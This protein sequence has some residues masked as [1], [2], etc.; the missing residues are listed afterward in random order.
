MGNANGNPK[1][2]E[3]PKEDG[4]MDGVRKCITNHPL[5]QEDTRNK[6]TRR[7]FVVGKGKPL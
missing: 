1:E 3:D 2:H 4:W 7:K 6:K 5:T